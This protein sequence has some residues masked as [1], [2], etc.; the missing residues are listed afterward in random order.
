MAKLENKPKNM[1]EMTDAIK[2]FDEIR[3][4]EK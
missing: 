3:N 4:N 2:S 1:T